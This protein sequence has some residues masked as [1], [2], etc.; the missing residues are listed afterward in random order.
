MGRRATPTTRVG[1]TCK[2]VLENPVP[3]RRL[4]LSVAVLV[5]R[6]GSVL[7]ICLMNL[8]DSLNFSL[9]GGLALVTGA[10]R[11]NGAAIARGMAKAGARVVAVDIDGPAAEAVAKG[12]CEDGGQAWGFRLDVAD[13]EA[14]RSL[15]RE[16]EQE[17]GDVT[18]LVNN[19]GILRRTRLADPQA[20]ESWDETLAVNVS[21]PFNVTH[22]FLPALRRTRGNVINIASVSSFVGLA[23]ST[24]YATSKG[25]VAQFTRTLAVE[26]A[27]DGIRVNAIA[28]GTI[29][30]DINIAMRS[31]EQR[32]SVFYAHTPMRRVGQPEEVVGPAVFLAS[33]AASYITGV[34][35]PVDGGY[36][37]V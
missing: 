36:L 4:Y 1:T 6:S 32:M 23:S 30:T 12:I 28:P 29:A 11:G 3:Y 25:A 9:E 17:A 13:R 5:P 7:V 31:D 21:G 24:S 15:V 26:L 33:R 27:P 22:A 16:V 35:L 2:I 19:A 18:C 20:F 14:C 34:I 37:T 8:I 10:G